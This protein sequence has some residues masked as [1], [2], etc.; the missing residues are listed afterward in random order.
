M[1]E[2]GVAAKLKLATEILFFPYQ[3]SAS[4]LLNVADQETHVGETR[5]KQLMRA[6]CWK[7]YLIL[8]RLV[9]L[10]QVY[11]SLE[12]RKFV[13]GN[14]SMVLSVVLIQVKFGVCSPLIF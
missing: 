6:D 13:D 1:K 10:A 14:L 3:P 11:R 5:C 7:Y 2:C 4:V 8:W 12:E 9:G